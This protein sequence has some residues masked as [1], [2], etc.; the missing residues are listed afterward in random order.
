MKL[1]LAIFV[2]LTL[3]STEAFPHRQHRNGGGGVVNRLRKRLRDPTEQQLNQNGRRRLFP[4]WYRLST[5]K[6]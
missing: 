1:H 5:P 3:V 6:L 2:L 4:R